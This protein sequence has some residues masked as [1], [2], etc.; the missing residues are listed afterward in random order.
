[1]TNTKWKAFEELVKKIYDIFLSEYDKNVK[2]DIKIKGKSGLEHQIDVFVEIFMPILTI[3]DIIDCKHWNSRVKKSD[4]KEIYTTR[5]EVNANRATIISRK[6]FQSGAIQFAKFNGIN[7]YKILK[8]EELGLH[9]AVFKVEGIKE[10]VIKLNVQLE[11]ENPEQLNQLFSKFHKKKNYNEVTIYNQKGEAIANVFDLMD[12]AF[13]HLRKI[14]EP[15]LESTTRFLNS[16]M[17][18]DGKK[19]K[20]NFI[21]I[22]IQKRPIKTER[23]QD[24]KNI[25][26]LIND[27][28]NNKMFLVEKPI[29]FDL[30]E[31]D[32]I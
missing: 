28:V 4:V 26:L 17:I 32:G 23:S 9:T 13:S 11:A 30:L 10:E 8:P 19:R 22:R 5:D 12:D 18:I 7:L 27:V 16:Y 3:K 29:G 31:K 14:P 25:K 15:G 20:V 6:G 21:E 2:H 1:M 24:I